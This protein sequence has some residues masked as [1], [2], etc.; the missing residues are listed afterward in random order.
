MTASIKDA[1]IDKTQISKGKNVKITYE[2][3]TNST[4]EIAKIRV[5]SGNYT[6]NK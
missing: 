1:Q 6:G 5:N 3:E 2:I 4:S